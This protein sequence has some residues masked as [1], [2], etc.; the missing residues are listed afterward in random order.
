[1]SA[2]PSR[3]AVSQRSHRSGIGGV[4]GQHGS[5]IHGHV[6]RKH[7]FCI[8][9]CNLA[10]SSDNDWGPRRCSEDVSDLSFYDPHLF[11]SFSFCFLT[12]AVLE[13]ESRYLRQ[14]NLESSFIQL[15]S[16]GRY[17]T[18]GWLFGGGSSRA[19]PPRQSFKRRFAKISQSRR[20]PP[21][22]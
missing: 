7:L 16:G 11:W 12:A 8:S 1:M 17:E 20:R 18:R 3:P 15:T 2:P 4:A 21:L 6:S 22:P 5:W 13:I 19:A 10:F 14:I 9:F